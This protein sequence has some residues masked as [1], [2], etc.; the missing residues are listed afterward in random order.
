MIEKNMW[1]IK[2]TEP[3]RSKIVWANGWRKTHQGKIRCGSRKGKKERLANEEI[4]IEQKG[5][6]LQ[7]ECEPS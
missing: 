2:L 4:K 7:G 6:S 5:M 1:S 3:K